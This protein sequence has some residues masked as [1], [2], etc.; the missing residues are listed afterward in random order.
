MF[1]IVVGCPTAWLLVTRQDDAG[2]ASRGRVSGLP[3]AESAGRDTAP[4]G[5]VR[6]E[7]VGRSASLL[8][9]RQLPAGAA[10]RATDQAPRRRSR[11]VLDIGW[12]THPFNGPFPGLPGWAGTRKVK[13]IWILLKQETVSGSGISRAIC[14]SAP[15]GYSVYRKKGG[16]QLNI[17]FK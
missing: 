2:R 10:R 12:H 8:L 16:S 6:R 7:A 3:T 13:P 4:A 15:R 5:G 1:Q 9:P 17:I 14:K 11:Q